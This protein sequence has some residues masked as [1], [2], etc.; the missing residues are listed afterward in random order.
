MASPTMGLRVV[1]E[2]PVSRTLQRV[3]SEARDE[4]DELW[5]AAF[6][7]FPQFPHWHLTKEQRGVYRMCGAG[8]RKVLCQISHGGLQVRVGGGWMGAVPFLEKYGPAGFN[9]KAPVSRPA[10]PSR[11]RPPRD[12]L[13]ASVGS[14][15]ECLSTIVDTPASMER[16]LVPTKCW[17]QKIGVNK[18]PD[19]REQ[20]RVEFVEDAPVVFSFTAPPA[21]PPGVPA[22]PFQPGA[23]AAGPLPARPVPAPSAG[24]AGAAAG[25]AAA[26]ASN[27][28]APPSRAAVVAAAI[29]G[30]P[31]VAALQPLPWPL[32]PSRSA[33]EPG[34]PRPPAVPALYV[35]EG[36]LPSELGE[37]WRLARSLAA[38]LSSAASSAEDAAA[39][40][41]EHD[42]AVAE[43]LA[44][45]LARLAPTV[46]APSPLA[47]GG[48]APEA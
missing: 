27:P 23:P 38:E 5:C 32:P 12:T 6:R 26:S 13:S 8:G 41:A 10:E 1:A 21:T 47:E 48:G 15:N 3:R 34:T 37:Q 20:R 46:D 39:D 42:D 19:L 36:S 35:A 25:R 33:S 45:I 31:L 30:V 28:T 7:R 44:A 11:S 9:F 2:V 24:A 40:A 18:S 22:A 29:A 16:L 14:L 17:A 4:I 43:K